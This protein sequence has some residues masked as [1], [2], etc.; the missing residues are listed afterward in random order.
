MVSINGADH[1]GG[2]DRLIQ[3][4]DRGE[5][6]VYGFLKTLRDLG[7]TGPIGLQC[8]MVPG[9]LALAAVELVSSSASGLLKDFGSDASGEELLVRLNP[10]PQLP[11]G[12]NR[13]HG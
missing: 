9:D 4:L 10:C 5:F 1:T 3:P 12:D 6:D 2:W 13:T 11:A 7:Y 8:Y